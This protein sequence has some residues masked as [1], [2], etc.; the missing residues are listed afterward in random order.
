MLSI[1]VHSSGYHIGAALQRQVA[2]GLERLYLPIMCL[3][4][5]NSPEEVDTAELFHIDAY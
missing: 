3:R 4:R 2:T 1:K 5:K